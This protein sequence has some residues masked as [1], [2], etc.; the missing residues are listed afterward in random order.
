MKII[1]TILLIFFFT[2]LAS[3]KGDTFM[4]QYPQLTDK[5]HIYE[6]VDINRVFDIID[7]QESCILVMG[8]QECPWCQ[9]LVP[10]LN[11]VG[12][13]EG[14]ERIYYL[15][16]K[17]MRDNE[18]SD[19]HAAYLDLKE[20]FID[21]VDQEKDRINAPTT[22]AIK[23]GELVGFHLDTVSTHMMEGTIL[24]PL[25]E[26]QVNELKDILTTLIKKIK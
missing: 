17:E 1:K 26:N 4:E 13:E 25:N 21:C 16:I 10:Y 8:F 15:D 3:C 20:Y 14:L 6:V 12:K 22:L 5:E 18:A 23:N 24:P 7:N 11:E 9:A 2:I 19:Q